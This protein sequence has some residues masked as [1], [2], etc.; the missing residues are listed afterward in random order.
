MIKVDFITFI[1]KVINMTRVLE[2]RSVRLKVIV[3]MEK[4]SAQKCERLIR[5]NL[6]T[7]KGSQIKM[8]ENREGVT[9]LFCLV[10]NVVSSIF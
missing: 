8:A 5:T 9:A 2:S 10:N 3:E 7:M 1:G 6:R 4:C